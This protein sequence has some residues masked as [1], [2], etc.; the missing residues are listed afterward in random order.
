MAGSARLELSQEFGDVPT[1]RRKRFRTLGILRVIAQKVAILFHIR[2][3]TCGIDDHRIYLSF[4]ERVNGLTREL[5]RLLLFSSMHQQGAAA[6]LRLRSHYLASLRS[7]HA[8]RGRIDLWEK[9]TLH[10]TEQQSNAASPFALRRDQFREC[11]LRRHLRQQR[12]HSPEPCW[13]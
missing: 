7:E 1:L 2:A 8:R 10:A 11:F 9:H 6:R 4:F 13:K 12:L 3:A 5:H